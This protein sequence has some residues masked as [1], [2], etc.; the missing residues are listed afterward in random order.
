MADFREMVNGVIGDDGELLEYRHLIANEKTRAIWKHSYGN[1]LGRLTQGM[2]GR[3]AGTN[4]MFF[5]RKDQLPR[6]RMKDVT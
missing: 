4:T 6:E 3:N 1:E 5:I 2:P